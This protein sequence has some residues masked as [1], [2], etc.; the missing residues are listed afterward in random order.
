MTLAGRGMVGTL[1]WVLL[2]VQT[3][4]RL[5]A[6]D[7]SSD[8]TED[9]VCGRLLA[10]AFDVR[11]TAAML[12][13]SAASVHQMVYSAELV[14]VRLG[15]AWRFPAW[16]FS[17]DGVVAGLEEIVGGWR[18]SFVRLS[19]WAGEPSRELGG[20]TPAEAL[21]D[22]DVLAVA[23]LSRQRPPARPDRLPAAPTG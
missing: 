5:I 11:E 13:V 7:P 21:N 19:I 15:G 6:M 3:G 12:G 22:G 8:V 23:A 16:Q 1:T 10:D 14:A 17:A 2:A 18:N 20:R 4:C 9:G